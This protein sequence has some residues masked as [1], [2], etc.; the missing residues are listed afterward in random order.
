[1]LVITFALDSLFSDSCLMASQQIL[2]RIHSRLLRLDFQLINN[3]EEDSNASHSRSESVPN[4]HPASNNLNPVQHNP[5][6]NGT[7]GL[8][9]RRLEQ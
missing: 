8:F 4:P 9:E 6:S 7:L 3:D 5:I 1:M 2:T